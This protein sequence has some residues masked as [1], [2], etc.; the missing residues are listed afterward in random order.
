MLTSPILIVVFSSVLGLTLS[1]LTR[2]IAQRKSF[3]LDINHFVP[4][5]GGIAIIATVVATL[6]LLNGTSKIQ[7]AAVSGGLLIAAVG[8]LDD[9]GRGSGAMFKLLASIVVAAITLEATGVFVA[10][11]NTPIL[12]SLFAITPI[13]LA[14]SVFGLAGMSHAVN[15]IDGIH[16]LALSFSIMAFTALG[17]IAVST[18]DTFTGNLTFALAGSCLGLVV[19]NFPSGSIFLGD[20]GSYFLGFMVA[21]AAISLCYNNPEI[22]PWAMVCIFAYPIVDVGYAAMRRLR[23]GKN[24]LRGDCEHLHHRVLRLSGKLGK[25]NSNEWIIVSTLSCSLMALLPITFATL[26]FAAPQLLMAIAACS[27]S[28]LIAVNWIVSLA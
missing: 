14:V 20:V 7:M 17:V 6:S 5:V 12:S 3:G 19:L 21:W 10:H 8:L 15:L 1:L 24:P 18:G 25:N 22:S 27:I 4:R 2:E 9:L 13:A 23:E 26:N 28:T 11:L 16:G